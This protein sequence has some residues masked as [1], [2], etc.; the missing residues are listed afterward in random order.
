MNKLLGP[1]LILAGMFLLELINFS[2]P[3]RGISDGFQKKV[4][5][6]GVWGAGL[7]GILFAL[8]FCPVSAALFFG[9]LIPLAVENQSS[10]LYPAVYGFGTGL[11]IVVLA[12]VLAFSARSLSRIFERITDFDRWARR[13]TGSVFLLVGIYF[14][15]K[16]IFGLLG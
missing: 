9:S 15:L 5:S 8:S 2:L 6:W 10:V 16:Y 4:R 7:M 14:C 11:P 3:G 1:V 12:I 13:V